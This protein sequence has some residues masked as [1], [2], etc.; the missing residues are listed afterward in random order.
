MPVLFTLRLLGFL[1]LILFL[2]GLS[3]PLAQE[4]PGAP[5]APKRM[6]APFSSPEALPR[7]LAEGA[8]ALEES[9][10]AWQ[11]RVAESG[12]ELV[13]A[14]EDL[15]NLQVAVASVKASLAVKK[16][17][18]SQVQ[19]LLATYSSLESDLKSRSKDLTQETAELKKTREDEVRSLNTLRTQMNVLRGKEPGGLTPE[20]EQSGLHYL[21]LA[22]ARDRLVALVLDNLE[23]RRLALDSE[24]Q[25]VAELLPQLKRLEE[26]W[27]AELLK[28]Q[29]QQVSFKEQMAR[30]WGA[31]AALPGRVWRWFR[32]LVESGSPSAFFWSHLAHLVG[33]LSFI[34]LMG[35]STRRLNRLLTERFRRWRAATDDL[36]LLPL[37]VL[38]LILISNL[39][40][41]GL[42][43][44]VGLFFWIF[45]MLG[46]TPAQLVL[47]AL[48]TLWA[49]RLGLQSVQAYIGGRP[50]GVALPLDEPTARFYRCTLKAFLFYLLL[51]FLGLKAAALLGFPPTSL[52]FLEH[53]FQVGIFLWVLWL[54]RRPYLARLLPALP[55]PAWVRRLDVMQAIRGL[56]WF[57][58][59]V[60]VLADLLGF[61][62]L[63]IYLAQGGTWTG[64]A[65]I[66]LWLLW[67]VA[68]TIFH[69]LLHPEEG[70][71]PR[72]YPEQQ[73]MLQRLY[74]AVR[75]L[76]SILLGAGVVLWSLNSWGIKPEGLAWAFQ[77]VTWGPTLGPMRLT[78]LNVGGALLAIYLG[79]VLSRVIRSL[80]AVR[81]FPRTGLDP[82]VQ[83]TIA[84]TLH[85]VVLILVAMVALNILG[86]PL[87]NLALVAGALGVGI[88]FGLQNIVN[89]FIS[90]LILLFER[91]I[92]VGDMLVIDGQWGTVREIRVRS[93]VFETFDR[94]VLIIPNSE[95]VSGKVLN[96]THYG[97]GINR[98]TLKVGVSYGSDVRLV[99]RLLT[100]V[101]RAN[102]RV[103]DEPPPEVY[104]AVYGDSSLDFTIW[105]FVQTPADRIPATHELNSAI[106]ETFREHG[107]EIPFPQRDLHI[108]EWPEAPEVPEKG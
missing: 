14:R 79:I 72:R 82:G 59:A 40:L 100:E 3:A 101:C 52:Q 91:P 68:A 87:T 104:F 10:G 25:L 31:V 74:G 46:A 93:T 103:V 106:F 71:A 23:G 94:Y 28:R 27:Q 38:G 1:G 66:L 58:L 49:L 44:W 47:Y 69:H 89:N 11:S 95:L 55:D 9:L 22:D 42:I 88:G 13:K 43:F 62:N 70:W 19:E 63:S 5:G 75:W 21:Q 73:E 57:L 83:Y 54:W 45:G 34:V 24:R 50:A 39:F 98:L 15:T 35:W 48:V 51:G 7:I 26:A 90:G 4:K 99:T 97:R 84:T 36:H 16:P 102:P 56:V 29:A 86:F 67:L 18:L 108:K 17:P 64:L 37:F 78:T 61:H 80:M 92:K 41:L 96:W 30:I 20:M 60:I 33:L 6:E 76:L 77:W 107:I 2:P 32:Q 65:I 85:Y 12:E 81:I 8:A 105:V 53:F